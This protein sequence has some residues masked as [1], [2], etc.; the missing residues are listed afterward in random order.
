MIELTSLLITLYI[1]VYWNAV[2]VSDI[3]FLAW[4]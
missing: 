4:N 1:S 3:Q 2:A